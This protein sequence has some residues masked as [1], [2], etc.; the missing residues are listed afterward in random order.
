MR[1]GG[2]QQ[3]GRAEC[4]G[5]SA[6]R[7]DSA[8]PTNLYIEIYIKASERASQCA[9]SVPLSWPAAAFLTYAVCRLTCHLHGMKQLSAWS[10]R[11]RGMPGRMT[12]GRFDE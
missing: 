7:K 6:R 4:A 3:F 11:N 12:L 2:E 1:S 8:L 5:T 10:G 9:A